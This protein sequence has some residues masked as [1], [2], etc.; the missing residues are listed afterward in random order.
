MSKSMV[1]TKCIIIKP[2]RNDLDKENVQKTLYLCINCHNYL[3]CCYSVFYIF[4]P[5]KLC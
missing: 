4:L 3:M 5:Y 1:K 2:L